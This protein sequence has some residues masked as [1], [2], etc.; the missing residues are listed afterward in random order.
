MTIPC[1]SFNHTRGLVSTLN[2][3]ILRKAGLFLRCFHAGIANVK[4]F[5]KILMNMN[6]EEA[7]VKFGNYLLSDERMKMIV[8]EDVKDKVSDSDIANFFEAN[9]ID[10][11]KE[12]DMVKLTE[13]SFVI[14]T[15]VWKFI[16]MKIELLFK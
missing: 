3:R 10:R 16:K 7:L 2:A 1:T 6:I 11:K 9:G 8:N 13:K 12:Y 4:Q 14:K 5:N 15:S